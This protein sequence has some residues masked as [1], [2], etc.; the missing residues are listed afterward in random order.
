MT[1]QLAEL[2]I[3]ELFELEEASGGSF[4]HLGRIAYTCASRYHVEECIGLQLRWCLLYQTEKLG[5]KLL[6]AAF[7][8]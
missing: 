2:L 8:L 3:R 1:R 6:W 7:E 5:D 4:E